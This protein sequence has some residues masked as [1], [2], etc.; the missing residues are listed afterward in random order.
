MAGT[1]VVT[2]LFV[3]L[4]ASTERR[5]RLGDDAFDE[6][7]RR[8]MAELRSAISEHQ[9]REVS[10]AG[11]GMM[12]VFPDSVVDAVAC[13]TSMHP[14][15]GALD[16]ADPPQLRIGISSG[17]VARDGDGYSGM[18]IVEAARLEAAAAPGQTLA[19]AVVRSLV[20]NRRAL[21]FRDVGE[22]TLKGIP[23]PLATVEVIDDEV[24]DVS[25]PV[26]AAPASTANGAHKGRLVA[27]AAVVVVIALVAAGVVILGPGSDQPES[28]HP[29]AQ[30]QA[31]IT[32]PKGYTTR[33]VRAKCPAH[34]LSAAAD[35]TCGHL[36]VPED[37]VK[38]AGEQVTL[39]V[40]RA[41]AR[42]PGPPAVPTIDIC[43]CEDLGNSWRATT[44][45]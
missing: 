21:R 7:T 40:T 1:Q 14:A 37:R 6:F 39:L 16:P 8:F 36:V 5:A 25:A 2:I 18:P 13:A 26:P 38:P 15:V 24:A 11:D 29:T 20:G 35:A 12:V 31:G 41:P 4:V 19:N 28:R 44:P 23:L 33:Y 43:G 32:A 10:S 34:V 9:G 42:L 30:P 27:I 22:L 17:E 3:D 45:N